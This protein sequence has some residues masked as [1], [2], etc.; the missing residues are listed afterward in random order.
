MSGSRLSELLRRNGRPIGSPFLPV[1]HELQI[2]AAD[3]SYVLEYRIALLPGA[4][5][6][7][8]EGAE[9]RGKLEYL[10]F[11]LAVYSLSSSALEGALVPAGQALVP[12]GRRVDPCTPAGSPFRPAG[13]WERQFSETTPQSA[14]A[15]LVVD[16]AT[17]PYSFFDILNAVAR[18]APWVTKV[19]VEYGAVASRYRPDRK[20]SGSDPG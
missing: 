1:G 4:T 18:D 9:R 11:P 14:A 3:E 5:N 8:I 12:R 2:W 7:A 10:Q 6:D 13:A 20:T 16:R 19:T 17:S 15:R